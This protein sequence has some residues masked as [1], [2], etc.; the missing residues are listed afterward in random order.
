MDI[1]SFCQNLSSLS[2]IIQK[3]YQAAFASTEASSSNGDAEPSTVLPWA[4]SALEGSL[5]RWVIMERVLRDG[6]S[7]I[8]RN[9]REFVLAE[10][11]AD[12]A[13]SANVDRQRW[14]VLVL[15][16]RVCAAFGLPA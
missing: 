14:E 13:M 2:F 9:V 8:A 16:V 4:L 5:Q 12:S 11:A 15:S 3:I 7:W 6:L 1:R 10:D